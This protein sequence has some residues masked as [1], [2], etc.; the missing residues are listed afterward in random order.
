MS[1]RHR[2]LSFSKTRVYVTLCYGKSL[3]ASPSRHLPEDRPLKPTCTGAA[4]ALRRTPGFTEKPVWFVGRSWRRELVFYSAFQ[5]DSIGFSRVATHGGA[6][7]DFAL[8]RCI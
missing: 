5:T 6:P 4:L 3:G 2:D 8:P 1:S 7:F